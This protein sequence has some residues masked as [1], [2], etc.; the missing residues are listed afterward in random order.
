MEDTNFS[1]SRA[2]PKFFQ[3]DVAD[4]G[5]RNNLI[6]PHYKKGLKNEQNSN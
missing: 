3:Q 5:P 1:Y 2:P 4:F 6:L